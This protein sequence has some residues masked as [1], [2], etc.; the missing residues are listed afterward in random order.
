MLPGMS[1]NKSDFFSSNG[2]PRTGGSTLKRQLTPKRSDPTAP[3][4]PVIENADAA[5][6]DEA[7]RIRMRRGRASSILTGGNAGVPMTASK[8]LLGE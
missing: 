2:L 8:V 5:R 4:P 3:P 6:Q 7:D 1:F